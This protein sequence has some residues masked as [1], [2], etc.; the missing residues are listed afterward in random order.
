MQKNYRIKFYNFKSEKYLILP[1]CVYQLSSIACHNSSINAVS[2]VNN[3]NNT[4]TFTIDLTVDVGG[5]DG[6]SFGFALIFSNTTAIPPLV[7]NPAF[8]PVLTSALY[9]DLTGYSGISIG[10]GLGA[11]NP[12]ITLMIAMEI[13]PMF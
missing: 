3:G 5:L 4:S 10:T 6:Y 11:V 13:E 8:T 7:I 2:Y 12:P 9:N 1:I